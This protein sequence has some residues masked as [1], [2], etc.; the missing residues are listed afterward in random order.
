VGQEVIASSRYNHASALW[1]S[2]WREG[3]GGKVEERRG[4]GVGRGGPLGILPF[5][6]G[7]LGT[8]NEQPEMAESNAI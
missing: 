5:H 8:R 7:Q 3:G 4:G 6:S 2:L 1:L